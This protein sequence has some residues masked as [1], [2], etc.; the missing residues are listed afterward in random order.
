MRMFAIIGG[1]LGTIAA[2]LGLGVALN[3]F[4]LK[5]EPVYRDIRTEGLQH[6]YGAVTARQELLV[7]LMLDYE[8]AQTEGQKKGIVRR[9]RQEAAMLG[10][11]QVP[12]EVATFLATH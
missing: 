3:I 7:N 12:Q 4:E 1:T 9:M 10:P 6:G 8:T 11:Q 2:L 5:M